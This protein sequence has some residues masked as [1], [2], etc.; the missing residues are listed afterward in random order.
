L[1]KKE[2]Q[3][4]TRRDPTKRQLSK[5]QRQQKTSRIIMIAIAVFFAGIIGYTGYGYYDDNIKPF[6]QVAIEVNDVSFNMGYYV[7]MLE[8][9]TRSTDPTELHAQ[10][11]SNQ[12]EQI[13]LMKQGAGEMGIE[14]EDEEVKA[15]IKELDLPDNRVYR[16]LVTADLLQQEVLTHFASQLPQ[17]MEQAN[18]RTILVESQ[19]VASEV[20]ASLQEGEDFNSLLEEFSCNANAS[21]ELGW[22]P[23]E[24]MPSTVGEVF[25]S[26]EAGEI[27]TINDSNISK[28]IGY[29][30]IKVTEKD[31]EKGIF[32]HT[33]LLS[34]RAKAMEIIEKLDDGGDFAEL[35]KEYSQ[36]ASKENGGE[37]GW[38]TE[39]YSGSEAFDE[40]AFNMDL[41]TV[42]APIRDDGINTQ[43][44]CWV[45]EVLDK[46]LHELDDSV[47][48]TLAGEDFNLWLSQLEES[49]TINNYLDE[50]MMA[51]AIE[52]VLEQR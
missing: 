52:E 8:I 39:G 7:D 45:V 12:I 3:N 5:W 36:D 14:V 24:M 30:I 27:K 10:Y 11:V 43:G 4:A 32:A 18:I 46:G 40:V 35:A 20:Q 2:K 19:E 41:D 15:K 16:D 1:S 21:G 37:L 22:L 50:E 6:K 29:W 26:L 48:E 47:K 38:I 49:S 25:P 13:E 33:M 42:S 9:Q 51:W 31:E 44:G 17:E 23:Q 28:N 34:S